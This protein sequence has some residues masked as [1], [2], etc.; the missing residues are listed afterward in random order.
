MKA[1]NALLELPAKGGV[2]SAGTSVSAIIIS[3]LSSTSICNSSLSFD[4]TSASKG[5]S[6][7]EIISD[8]SQNAEVRV[9]LLTVSDTV[10]SGAGP[11]RRYCTTSCFLY[12]LTISVFFSLKVE[13]FCYSSLP[14]VAS[15]TVKHLTPKNQIVTPDGTVVFSANFYENYTCA[16]LN[17]IVA[18]SHSV[19]ITSVT[20]LPELVFKK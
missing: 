13:P 16:L 19:F 5:S 12:V 3:D 4:P 6:S 8:E 17:E 14:L 10:A 7:Q 2:I 15:L 18:H 1:A 9:A 11:D 20:H